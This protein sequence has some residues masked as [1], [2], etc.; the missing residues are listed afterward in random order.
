MDP[1]EAFLEKLR[2]TSGQFFL[3]GNRKAIRIMKQGIVYCPLTCVGEVIGLE[4]WPAAAK[5]LGIP[6]IKGLDIVFAADNEQDDPT[7]Q[8]GSAVKARQKIRQELLAACHIDEET[9]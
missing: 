6:H 9:A 1:Y 5:N 7:D 8:E 2:Q 3:M 4:K